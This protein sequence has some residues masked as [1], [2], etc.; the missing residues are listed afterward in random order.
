MH[1]HV[2][3]SKHVEAWNKRIVKQ[4]FCASSWLITGINVLRCMVSKT[5]KFETNFFVA[6]IIFILHLYDTFF[7]ENWIWTLF[8]FI[9]SSKGI[10]QI[11]KIYKSRFHS[12]R[13]YNSKPETENG[14]RE[15]ENLIQGSLI[16]LTRLILRKVL[17]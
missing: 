16:C 2:S 4:K 13:P 17:L 3:S 14:V 7:F 15:G 1:I 6:A 10:I 5:S 12:E 11:K 9:D 8:I